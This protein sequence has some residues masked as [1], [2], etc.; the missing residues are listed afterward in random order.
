MPEVMWLQWIFLIVGLILG[1]IACS[2]CGE[3]SSSSSGEPSPVEVMHEAY[4]LSG[5]PEPERPTA[6]LGGQSCV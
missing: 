2:G 4:H 3:L 5:G 6:A 1:F